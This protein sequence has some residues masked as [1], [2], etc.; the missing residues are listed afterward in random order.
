MWRL[1]RGVGELRIALAHVR[2]ITALVPGVAIVAGDR[3][4]ISSEVVRF[5]S[6]ERPLDEGERNGRN[7]VIDR[8]RGLV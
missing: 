4:I 3:N 2:A 6:G 7:A 1:R 8:R 5:S